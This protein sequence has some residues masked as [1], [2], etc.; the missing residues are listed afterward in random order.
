MWGREWVIATYKH[1]A[2]PS[3]VL[4]ISRLATGHVGWPAYLVSQLFIATTYVF[5]F[6]LGRDLMG[7]ARAAAGTL[8]L[9]GISFFAWPTPEFNHNVAV[10]PF[11]AALPWVLWRAVDRDGVGWWAL[12]GA[13]AAG[14]LY[15]KLAMVLLLLALGAWMI[16][17]PQARRSLATPGPWIALALFALIAAPLAHWLV[18]HDFAPLRYAAERAGTAERATRAPAGNVLA[19]L[20]NQAVNLAGLVAM[21]AVARLIGPAPKSRPSDRAGASSP[22][23]MAPGAVAYLGML[24]AGPLVMALASALITGSSLRSAWGSSMFNFAG[25]LAVALVFQRVDVHALRRIAVCAAVALTVVP[26]AYAI[27]VIAGP[28]RGGSPMR[29]NWPQAAIAERF[30][31]I[32]A[33]ETGQPLRIV[34]GDSWIAGLVGVSNRDAPSIFT[35][36]D[37][38]LSPWITPER[39]QREGLLI[40]WDTR[41]GRIPEALQ[42]L[43]AA[44]PARVERFAWR[45]GKDLDELTIGYAV[46]PPK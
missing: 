24:T 44:Q 30:A 28:S 6:L 36:G 1:P 19:F 10:T 35:R 16:W 17:E 7:P 20:M 13:L 2:L 23:W 22:A 46:V 34:G 3:W 9:T 39:L 15:S 18:T 5:V 14:G 8:L 41:T 42:A 43:V 29:V 38:T 21:L 32:W 12:A 26:L 33:R 25:L 27:V 4:E 11:W 37:R 40:V 45:R 31:A